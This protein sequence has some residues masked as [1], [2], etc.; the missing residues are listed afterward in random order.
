MQNIVFIF[1]YS[2]WADYM[3]FVDMNGERP[4]EYDYLKLS[5]VWIPL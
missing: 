1:L 2:E 3:F 4:C 5:A